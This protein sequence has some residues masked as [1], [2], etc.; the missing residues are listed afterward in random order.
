MVRFHDQ[1]RDSFNFP[2]GLICDPGTQ[3]CSPSKQNKKGEG[4]FTRLRKCL[5]L[6]PAYPSMAKE[7]DSLLSH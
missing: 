4:G 6:T 5:A 1:K 3:V 2:H 7:H